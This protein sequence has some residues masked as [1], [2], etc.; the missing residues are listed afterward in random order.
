VIISDLSVS[1]HALL[2]TSRY[3][4]RSITLASDEIL[5][6]ED[7][8][9]TF[10][11]TNAAEVSLNRRFLSTVESNTGHGRLTHGPQGST[12]ETAPNSLPDPEFHR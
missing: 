4:N 7:L 12:V 2:S 9:T 8:D 6:L 5:I 10:G 3:I 11:A 1:V